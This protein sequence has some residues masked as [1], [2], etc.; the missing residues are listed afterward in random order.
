[1]SDGFVDEVLLVGP[2]GSGIWAR[3]A[4]VKE[5][6]LIIQTSTS[7]GIEVTAA[8]LGF[9]AGFDPVKVAKSIMAKI[10]TVNQKGLTDSSR[11]FTLKED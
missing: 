5:G 6:K 7:S 1:M 3:S 2:N 4:R 8:E 10:R 11:T 9:V